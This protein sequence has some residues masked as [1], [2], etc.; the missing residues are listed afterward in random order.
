[1]DYNDNGERKDATKAPRRNNYFYGKLLDELH[2]RMEQEY[3]NKK[4]WL[5][6]RLSL[7]EGVLCGLQVEADNGKVCVKPGVAIDAHGR[8]IVVPHTTCIDPWQLTDE[9]GKKAGELS[10]DGEHTIHI[11][12]AY[13]EC[14][15]D[16]VPVLVT[17][18]NTKESCAPGTIVES[19]HLLVR[20]G[21]PVPPPELITPDV[22]KAL[23]GD[24]DDDPMS[25]VAMERFRK[26]CGYLSGACPEPPEKSCII[27]ATAILKDN[28]TI[29]P[30]N[31]CVYRK[32]VYSNAMLLNLILCL[33]ERIEECCSAITTPPEPPKKPF[34]V[35]AVEF[36]NKEGT[37]VYTIGSTNDPTV[38]TSFKLEDGIKSIQVT[39][40]STVKEETI[41]YGPPEHAGKYSFLVQSDQSGFTMGCVTGE[42]AILDRHIALFTYTG[43]GDSFPVGEY[44]VTLFGDP[45]ES[46]GRPA[47]SSINDVRLDGAPTNALPSGDGTE[48]G[49]FVFHFA[50]VSEQTPGMWSWWRR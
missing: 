21:E 16:Y 49:N 13:H 15:A 29:D 41:F 32:V 47:I 48:G 17:D 36:I 38:T 30:I 8:E 34:N 40:N 4:R 50:I 43:S 11:C 10:K 6:N 44:T 7:G 24:E 1:M 35:T 22:C 2:F 5:M 39:F 20:E 26:L 31:T 23:F 46:V 18:C 9:C 37:A 25:P 19:F 14:T 42:I 28:G 3:I 27:L 33:A 12:L 45:D